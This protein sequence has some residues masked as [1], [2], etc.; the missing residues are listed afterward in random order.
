MPSEIASSQAPRSSRRTPVSLKPASSS[1]PC[2][3]RWTCATAPSLPSGPSSSGS[4]GGAKRALRTKRCPRV[5]R[6]PVSFQRAAATCSVIETRIASGQRRCTIT[7]ST[8]G[9]RRTSARTAA[10]STEVRPPRATRATA[11]STCGGDTRWNA[12]STSTRCTGRSSA[13]ASS[14]TTSATPASI[15][16]PVA[17]RRHST[18][19]NSVGA[20]S[21]ARRRLRA[22]NGVIG[23]SSR[24]PRRKARLEHAPDQLVEIHATCPG[25]LRHQ[26]MAGHAG[27]GVDLEQPRSAGAV[28]HEI[29]ATPAA[30]AR[31]EKGA[32]REAAELLLRG[33]R[34][35]RTD[36][37]GIVGD[38]LGVVV[39]V[40]TRGHDAD[41]GQC[42]AAEHTYGVLVAL[43]ELLN[44][45][46][47]VVARGECHGGGQ[48][49]VI[50]AARYAHARALAGGLDDD[51]QPDPVCGRDDVVAA[52][53]TDIR[54]RRQT[55]RE[56]HLLGADLVHRE[57]RAEHPG[58][59]VRHAK[60]VQEPLYDAVLA[61]APVAV[62]DVEH[63]V[64]SPPRRLRELG[65]QV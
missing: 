37:L 17:S 10:R 29:D 45:H 42:L 23:M 56:P 1:L 39:V 59:G 35:A 15:P 18:R 36:V 62:K 31:G 27:R 65:H 55:E 14:I 7:P 5:L 64:D 58:S 46:R 38:V 49:R 26:R 9:I 32:E 51:R 16:A 24:P 2:A 25:G 47:A 34:E 61:P 20:R 43:D 52:L 60:R 54:R 41:R 57:R 48:V 6:S 28:T 21:V 50:E 3:S 8:Q 12:P 44:Q 40:L 11:L 13:S 22:V 33:T 19:S 30:A 4:S 63:P 53:E